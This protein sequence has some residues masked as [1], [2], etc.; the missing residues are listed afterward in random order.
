MLMYLQITIICSIRTEVLY[1]IYE[2]LQWNTYIKTTVMKQ[3]K[4]FNGDHKPEHKKTTNR[5]TLN[6]STEKMHDEQL[7]TK[8]N[9]SRCSLNISSKKHEHTT[10]TKIRR[11]ILRRLTDL[12][13]RCLSLIQQFWYISIG[14]KIDL[15]YY[16][17]IPFNVLTFGWLVSG[18][19]C[20]LWFS[21][22]LDFSLTFFFFFFFFY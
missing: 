5:T 17:G 19:G 9:W 7:V 8:C 1:L 18:K 20:G 10:K 4:G 13:F 21:H 12:G 16:W 2:T 14:C 11:R 22:S 3:S 15:L 6:Q